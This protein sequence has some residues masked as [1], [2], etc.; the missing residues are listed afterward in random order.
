LAAIV[1]RKAR[2]DSYTEVRRRFNSKK[3]EEKKKS[4]ENFEQMTVKVTRNCPSP[5]QDSFHDHHARIIDHHPSSILML[6]PHGKTE[7]PGYKCGGAGEPTL[8]MKM[9]SR[10]RT[11]TKG[12]V[13]MD[14]KRICTHRS[15]HPNP[16]VCPCVRPSGD[17]SAIANSP[18]VSDGKK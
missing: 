7:G 3:K 8:S 5:Q 12:H 2:T 11:K 4:G 17:A 13:E 10:R 14:A 15:M 18:Y 9:K 16:C 1:S 6:K